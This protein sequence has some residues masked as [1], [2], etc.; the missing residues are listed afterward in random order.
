M[1]AGRYGAARCA[2]K[3]VRLV[4][5]RTG[6]LICVTG[7]YDLHVRKRQGLQSRLERRK[8]LS[9]GPAELP[10]VR[11]ELPEAP[12]RGLLARHQAPDPG[13][14]LQ[15]LVQVSHH[16]LVTRLY[17]RRSPDAALHELLEFQAPLPR[18][19]Q[20]LAEARGLDAEHPQG[21][22]ERL[23]PV[24]GQLSERGEL[25]V[26]PADVSSD[27]DEVGL[28]AADF[29]LGLEQLDG[30]LLEAALDSTRGVE[31]ACFEFF[32]HAALFLREGHLRS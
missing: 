27:E 9:A 23:E 24:E 7:A 31:E 32:S 10:Q 30:D 19:P 28:A 18:L 21:F 11:H 1:R 2:S 20:R 8:R 5:G 4:A 29:S 25:G 15:R 26:Q 13:H 17:F 3:A 12:L 16:V 22:G 6:S 14:R